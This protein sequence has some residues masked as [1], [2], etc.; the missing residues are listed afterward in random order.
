MLSRTWRTLS[1]FYFDNFC[2]L[3]VIDSNSG[4]GFL[5]FCYIADARVI[6]RSGGWVGSGRVGGRGLGVGVPEDARALVH[7]GLRF[8]ALG[9]VGFRV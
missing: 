9:V 7:V 4:A 6:K 5:L 2:F 3:V 1:K 8:R